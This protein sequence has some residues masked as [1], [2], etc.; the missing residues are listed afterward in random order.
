[1]AAGAAAAVEVVTPKKLYPFSSSILVEAKRKAKKGRKNNVNKRWHK[2][3]KCV[4][5]CV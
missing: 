2:N 4:C 1:M 5:V 3:Q